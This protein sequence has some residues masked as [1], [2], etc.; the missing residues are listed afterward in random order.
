MSAQTFTST[1][2]WTCP[3]NVT[4]VQAE[5][6]A[7]GG[8]GGFASAGVGGSAVGGGGGGGAYAKKN[9]IAVTPG[10]VYTVTVGLGGVNNESGSGDGNDSWFSTSGTVLAKAGL[11]GG[12]NSGIGAA[13]GSSGSCIGDV[14]TS[15]SSG[16][17][18]SGLTSGAG[19]TGA[20][21]SG[22]VGGASV[23]AVSPQDLAGNIGTVPGGGGSG[24]SVAHGGSSGSA[25]GGNGADGKIILTYYL[26][27]RFWVGG[28]GNWDASTTT[29]WSD[30][31]GGTSGAPVP[32]SITPVTVDAN[33]GSGTITVTATSNCT[34]LNFTG[35][36]I[37]TFAGSSALNIYGSMTLISGLT[38]T[39]SGAVNFLSTST[40]KTITTAGKTLT[41]LIF[42]ATGGGWTLQDNMTATS[43]TLT[44]GT[45]NLSSFT[46]TLTGSGTPW[47]ANGG[48]ISGGTSTIKLTNATSS[49][50]TFAGGG[51][52][53]NNFYITGSGTGTYTISGNNTFNDFKADTP[54]HTI[55][56][57]ALSV[58]QL[59]TFTVNGTAG[60]LMTL[61][62]TVSGSPW[63]LSK[64]TSGVV[65]CDYLSIQD[66]H[67]N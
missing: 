61:Q 50:K 4:S 60:N 48:S 29:N 64:L 31:S 46:V 25:N 2:T 23:T 41:A 34:D 42:N 16:G 3:A 35:S 33:S 49:S 5:C 21:P 55:I 9:V 56:F 43:V 12:D 6:W 57:T 10:N 39:Y 32:T 63:R 14:V 22:G 20:N 11:K 24:A 19:G 28:N 44:A 51:L 67:A 45:L 59:Q 15:G 26:N 1:T 37:G 17:N 58:Q 7:G 40:G 52:T 30:S 18:N 36:S 47:N 8:S 27:V 65:S 38:F 13:G 53:Y 54:P 62:S 66:S